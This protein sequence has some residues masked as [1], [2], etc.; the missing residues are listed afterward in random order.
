MGAHHPLRSGRLSGLSFACSRCPDRCGRSHRGTRPEETSYIDHPALANTT[1][2]YVVAAVDQEGNFT[3]DEASG[4]ASATVI[5][6]DPHLRLSVN[7]QGQYMLEW[8]TAFYGWILQESPNP[9][10]GSW[11]DSPLI[12]TVAGN[13]YQVMI[14]PTPQRRFFR[15]DYRPL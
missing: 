12:P 7:P 10:S 4:E 9:T 13:Q 1:Y 14:V 15:L 2:Y 8:T 3:I 6:P 11:S 5:L